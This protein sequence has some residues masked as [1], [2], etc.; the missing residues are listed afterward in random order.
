[1]TPE[2]TFESGRANVNR[3]H[4]ERGAV[5]MGTD[6]PLGTIEQIVMDGNT[7]ELRA[8]VIGGGQSGTSEVA[9]AA[10]HVVPGA[11]DGHQVNL[12]IGMADIRAHP[13]L[14]LPYD[15]KQYVPVHEDLV[16]PSSEARSAA[17]FSERPVVTEI[18]GNAAE[19]M[20]PGPSSTRLAQEESFADDLDASTDDDLDAATTETAL[21]PDEQ[22]TIV[23]RAQRSL[24]AREQELDTSAPAVDVEPAIAPD[25][26]AATAAVSSIQADSPAVAGQVADETPADMTTAAPS[27]DLGTSSAEPEVGDADEDVWTAEASTPDSG[28]ERHEENS[29]VSEQQFSEVLEVDVPADGEAI[30]AEGGAFMSDVESSEMRNFRPMGNSVWVAVPP[31]EESV[32]W[33]QPDYRWRSYNFDL[34]RRSGNRGVVMGAVLG[35]IAAMGTLLLVRRASKRRASR[36]RVKTTTAGQTARELARTAQR[37]AVAA[38]E[39]VPAALESAADTARRMRRTVSD[40]PGRWRWFRRGVRVGTAVAVPLAQAQLSR[41]KQTQ[42]TAARQAAK[43]VQ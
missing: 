13:E 19:V 10:S 40:L 8:L 42:D 9:I 31:A 36:L 35:L 18:R 20:L 2:N 4:I 33:Q 29:F 37:Q 23:L 24:T 14:A 34:G 5:A 12:D 22:P 25:E 7:G 43:A 1:M 17:T 38:K 21:T 27:P 32:P 6:G 41:R 39:A 11:T 15:P 28:E 30:V 26:V 3:V 16:L